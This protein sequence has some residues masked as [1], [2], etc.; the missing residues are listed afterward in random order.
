MLGDLFIVILEKQLNLFV[1]QENMNGEFTAMG[2]IDL[3][4]TS[5]EQNMRQ[6]I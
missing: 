2:L 1:Y 5:R 3:K 4:L 6:V